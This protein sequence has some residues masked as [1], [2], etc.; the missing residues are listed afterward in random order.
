MGAELIELG[1]GPSGLLSLAPATVGLVL[2]DLPSGST[3]ADFDEPPDLPALWSATWHALRP[4]GAAVF[5][6]SSLRFASRL[7]ASQEKHF[8]H[9][10]IWHK[11]HA[12]GHLNAKRAPM[13]AH[14]FVLVFARRPGVYHPQMRQGP[15][16]IWSPRRRG[17]GGNYGG[18]AESQM[19]SCR[20][21]AT[22]RYPVS[23]LS[24]AGVS[25][26]RGRAHPQQKP[27][28]LLRWLIRSYSNPGDLVAD[29]YAGSG[30]TGAAAIAEGRTFRGWDSCPRFG[31]AL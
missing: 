3:Q 23:V 8:R 12:T 11:P 22:D 20:T 5:L 13:R 30:S 26:W 2:S 6:A 1:D 29:P 4:D 31:V 19:L 9:D 7:L 10:L 28:P 16:P 27:E 25:N 17:H 18:G 24:F 21:G 14:E 15:G